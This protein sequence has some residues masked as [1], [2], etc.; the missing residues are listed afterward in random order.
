MEAKRHENFERIY[1]YISWDTYISV[2]VT[3]RVS[4]PILQYTSVK[5]KVNL[6]TAPTSILPLHLQPMEPRNG[7]PTLSALR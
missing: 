4:L 3:E 6:P 5:Q 1:L 7:N 2:M